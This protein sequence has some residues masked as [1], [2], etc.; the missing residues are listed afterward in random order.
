M[1]DTA[2]ASQQGNWRN[3]I[4]AALANCIDSRSIVWGPVALALWK[5]TNG[6]SDNLI[7]LGK[8]L[9]QLQAERG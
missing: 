5:N 8:A 3:T 2:H 7:G 6:L 1:T 4:L 9:V